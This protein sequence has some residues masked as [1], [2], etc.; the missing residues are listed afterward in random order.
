VCQTFKWTY[1]DEA[2]ALEHQIRTN[3]R[4]RE[5]ENEGEE[6]HRII[7]G[8]HVDTPYDYERQWG[9]TE[10]PRGATDQGSE[11]NTVVIE[12]VA[13]SYPIL[14]YGSLLSLSI[15]ASSFRVSC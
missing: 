11:S 15:I 13:Q 2:R 14:L 7:I 5:K 3:E 1:L 10:G 9:V 12:D 4:Q 8:D 6:S